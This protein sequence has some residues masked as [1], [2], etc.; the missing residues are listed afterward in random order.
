[1]SVHCGLY[2][3]PCE[4][5]LEFLHRALAWCLPSKLQHLHTTQVSHQHTISHHTHTWQVCRRLTRDGYGEPLVAGRFPRQRI[6]MEALFCFHCGRSIVD[7]HCQGLND[8][9]KML[10][11][12]FFPKDLETATP[13]DNV[14]WHASWLDR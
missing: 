13:G 2:S 14:E 4:A 10:Y 12:D 9:N 7:C 5:K 8:R 11:L 3:G 6:T 1:M